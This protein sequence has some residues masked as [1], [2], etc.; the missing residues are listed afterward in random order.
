MR[1]EAANDA[2]ARPEAVLSTRPLYRFAIVPNMPDQLPWLAAL[3]ES[4]DWN[5]RHTP[6]E[7]PSSST[8]QATSCPGTRGNEANE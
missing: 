2:E 7:H 5:Y 1:P 3:A 8:T 6:S 4:E